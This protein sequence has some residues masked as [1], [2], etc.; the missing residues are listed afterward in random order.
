VKL[1]T[2]KNKLKRQSASSILGS[3]RNERQLSFNFGT[4]RNAFRLAQ[5]IKKALIMAVAGAT[6]T[7]GI[8][9]AFASSDS[10]LV[11]TNLPD[12]KLGNGAIQN[13]HQ[14]KGKLNGKGGE[15][16]FAK[17][18]SLSKKYHTGIYH[19]V[20]NG[21]CNYSD[22]CNKTMEA[23]NSIFKSQAMGS[24]RQTQLEKDIINTSQTYNFNLALYEQNQ[25]AYKVMQDIKNNAY[26]KS[27]LAMLT[28]IDSQ[29]RELNKNINKHKEVKHQPQSI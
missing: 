5:S 3:G 20:V 13:L 27:Q 26:Q 2:L 29:L 9:G 11:N 14:N 1:S 15:L 16:I 6:L 25:N 19:G 17:D 28:D 18:V 24:A 7:L 21:S 10:G 8:S 12:I 22:G 4:Q 23:A